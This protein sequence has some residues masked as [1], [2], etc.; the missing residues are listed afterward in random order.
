MTLRK[1]SPYPPNTLDSSAVKQGLPG[2]GGGYVYVG[3]GAGF[4]GPPVRILAPPEV[5]AFDWGNPGI[6][7]ARHRW[8]LADKKNDIRK[9]LL[10]KC[11]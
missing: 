7:A 6:G 3:S 10:I 1:L 2:N 11:F 8:G 5:T 4:G 9:K